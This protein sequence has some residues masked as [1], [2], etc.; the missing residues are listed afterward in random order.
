MGGVGG[1]GGPETVVFH[2]FSTG[3]PQVFHKLV[4]G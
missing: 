1:E 3:F 4:V 2:K